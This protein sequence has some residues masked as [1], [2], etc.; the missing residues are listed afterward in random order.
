MEPRAVSWYAD[1]WDGVGVAHGTGHRCGVERGIE[2]RELGQ[3]AIPPFLVSD[4]ELLNGN[5]LARVVA[6]QHEGAQPLER[7]RVV[8]VVQHRVDAGGAGVVDRGDGAVRHH[9]R[10]S[11]DGRVRRREDARGAGADRSTR[12]E[13][14]SRA[15]S[16]RNG[17]DDAQ[18]RSRQGAR[19]SWVPPHD[20]VRPLVPRKWI[21]Q[22]NVTSRPRPPN[23]S[24]VPFSTAE[25]SLG[26]A[27]RFQW[28]YPPSATVTRLEERGGV[29]GE[30]LG[31]IITPPLLNLLA[32]EARSDRRQSVR[33]RDSGRREGPQAERESVQ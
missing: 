22:G 2:A 33:H 20:S 23:G 3:A 8:D 15:R 1:G 30:I 16:S 5:R 12:S 11:A 31:G 7:P 19:V 13:E 6:R 26:C 4:D 9:L 18:Q 21:S 29:I 14:D 32:F 28:P 17:K 25:L 10:R 27:R 24:L